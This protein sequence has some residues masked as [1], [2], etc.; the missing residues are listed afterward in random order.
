MANIHT[1]Q[2]LPS[3]AKT[4]MANIQTLPRPHQMPQEG[5]I[6][7]CLL[8]C[9]LQCAHCVTD[10]NPKRKERL[11]L[12]EL[13]EFID[14]AASAGVSTIGF[15]GGDPFLLKQELVACLDRAQKHGMQTIV[16]TS[17]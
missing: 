1:L 6:I 12:L 11:S 9:P 2:K 8:T 3:M 15:T 7:Q 13:L 4:S 17:A 5:L 10:S 16:I 14:S